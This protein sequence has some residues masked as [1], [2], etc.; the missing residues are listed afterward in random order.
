LRCPTLWVGS[1]VKTCR[2]T[3]GSFIWTV[4]NAVNCVYFNA[5]GSPTHSRSSGGNAALPDRRDSPK[6]HDKNTRNGSGKIVS[7]LQGEKKFGENRDTSV[8]GR[9]RILFPAERKFDGNVINIVSNNNS[10]KSSNVVDKIS[11][12]DGNAGKKTPTNNNRFS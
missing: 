3:N 8:D 12:T 6:P 5:S 4:S 7:G 10:D 11:E 2:G 1:L 9:E